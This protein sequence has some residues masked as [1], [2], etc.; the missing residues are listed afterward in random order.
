V[1]LIIAAFLAAFRSNPTV[2]RV[3]YGIRPAST[4]LIAS[5]GIGVMRL[6]LVDE[7]AYA[8]TGSMLS[9]FHLPQLL[10][11]AAVWIMTNRVK[12]LKKLHP[13]AFI[14]FSAVVGIVFSF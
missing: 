9:L 7:A 10:L 5:A 2:E 12:P 11:L 4:A 8:A 13:L 14:A 3:F 1:I 6:C